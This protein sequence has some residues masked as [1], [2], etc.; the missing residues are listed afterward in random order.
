MAVA[1]EHTVDFTPDR[2]HLL[3]CA[4][5]TLIMLIPIG[6]EPLILCW[7]LIVPALYLW[8]I[9]RARTHV[10]GGGISTRPAFGSA[11]SAEWEE[12]KGVAFEKS[13]AMVH[14]NSGQ[15]FSLPAVSFNDLPELSAASSGRITDALTQAR[16]DLDE[17]VTIT[18]PDGSHQLV[19]R[20][21]FAELAAQGKVQPMPEHPD[22]APGRD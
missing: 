22:N 14:L 19:T 12:V 2:T 9:L 20:E 18:R 8:W 13:K 5:M 15:T 11:H 3:V 10:D 21:E 16:S 6:S 4:V 1:T 17:M 7:F